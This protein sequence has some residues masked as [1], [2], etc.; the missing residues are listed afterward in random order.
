[1]SS[2]DHTVEEVNHDDFIVVDNI[3]DIALLDRE[4]R[5]HMDELVEIELA[6]G[7]PYSD[8]GLLKSDK[9]EV[10]KAIDTLHEAYEFYGYE[11]PELKTTY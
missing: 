7:C 10:V 4:L 2:K 9:D 3:V 11:I 8:K 6:Y 5:L 1:M